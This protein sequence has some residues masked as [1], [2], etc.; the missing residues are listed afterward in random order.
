M[1]K[2]PLKSEWLDCMNEE[3]GWDCAYP[4]CDCEEVDTYSVEFDWDFDDLEELEFEEE[5]LEDE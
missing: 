1:P 2:R 4:D 5:E 3:L